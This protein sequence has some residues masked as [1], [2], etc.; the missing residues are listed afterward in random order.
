MNGGNFNTIS[1]LLDFKKNLNISSENLLIQ[2]LTKI[3]TNL[4]QREPSFSNK[5]LNYKKLPNDFNSLSAIK[6]SLLSPRNLLPKIIIDTGINS[7]IFLEYMDLQEFI[8]E[9]LFKYFNKSKTNLLSKSE[10]IEGLNNLYY[11]D[12]SSLIKLSFFLCDFNEDGKIYKSDMR[13]LLVY[14]PSS[15]EILQKMKI[16]QIDKILNSFFEE[17]IKNNEKDKEKE[18]DLF[19]YTKFINEYNNNNKDKDKKDN[20]NIDLINEFNNNGPFF[21]FISIL[22]YLFYNCPFNIKN[23]NQ[24]YFNDFY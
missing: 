15:S 11:G 9:R 13:L 18:I 12:I 14:I 17:N 22:S 8:G 19:T 21:Y 24:K 2:Y 6:K 20:I 4:T 7:K 10:F 1:E 5:T 16:K 3:Y 23:I